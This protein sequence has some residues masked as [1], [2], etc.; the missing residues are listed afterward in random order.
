MTQALLSESP[1]SSPEPEGIVDGRYQL[2]HVLA[3][4]GCARVYA[5][6]HVFTHR[7]VALKLPHRNSAPHTM[8]RTRREIELLSRVQGPGIVELIDA[9][10]LDGQTYIA[11]EL[12]EGRTLGGLLAARGKLTID[13]TLKVGIEVGHALA[14]C[15]VRSVLHR[16]V[17]PSNLFITLD[18]HLVLLDFGIAK[19]LAPSDEWADRVTA[20]HAVPG[21]PEY[22]A[23]ESLV[24][25]A[26]TSHADQYSL[27]VTLYECLTGTVPFDG[28]QGEVLMKVTDARPP[29]VKELRS[30]I[31]P[32]FAEVI[33]RCLERHPEDRFVS[34]R[35]LVCAL[36]A[37]LKVKSDTIN[38]LFRGPGPLNR[39]REATT[40]AAVPTAKHL[41]DAAT[42]RK[43]P[44]VPYNTLARIRCSDGTTIDGRVEEVSEGGLQF[45]GDRPIAIGQ[46]TFIRFALPASGRVTEVNAI[47]RW[48]RS[49]RGNNATGFE[50]A[51]IADTARTEIAKYAEIMR[52]E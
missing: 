36:E 30:D 5:A 21:T 11:L 39:E 34:A 47:S 13:E 48:N 9:N 1:S 50:F 28:K 22:M 45:V 17:K 43:H 27:G 33:D 29:S 38:L 10:E 37:C 31:S 49:L 2:R 14:R 25:A 7:M 16:D 12:L 26:P 19:L 18:E 42:R 52:G 8:K 3:S 4:G 46:S 51:Q 35:E 32:E 6:E 23:P 24:G 15:H 41:N 20:D 44:R 40:L